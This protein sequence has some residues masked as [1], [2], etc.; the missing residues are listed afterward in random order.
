MAIMNSMRPIFLILIFKNLILHSNTGK[1]F[2]FI[3]F[4]KYQWMEFCEKEI[5]LR[6]L[7]H[8]FLNHY[9]YVFRKQVMVSMMLKFHVK[10]TLPNNNYF[11]KRMDPTIPDCRG[12]Y[13][14][15]HVSCQGVLEDKKIPIFILCFFNNIQSLE[16]IKVFYW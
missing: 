16:S 10:L 15:Y 12:L 7:Q 9:S 4:G 2:L 11:Q 3:L 14:G 8:N 13:L 6:V 1:F 5:V